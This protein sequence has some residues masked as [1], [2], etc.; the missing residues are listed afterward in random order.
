[1]PLGKSRSELPTV[2][3]TDENISRINGLTARPPS[4]GLVLSNNANHYTQWPTVLQYIDLQEIEKKLKYKLL[5]M[6]LIMNQ[7]KQTSLEI[8]PVKINM[9]SEKHTAYA[10][11]WYGLSLALFII[12]IVVNTKNTKKK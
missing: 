5:P 1:L 11:Q 2:I 9:R 6:V 7:A 10:F 3:L 4:K 8:L 12:Y